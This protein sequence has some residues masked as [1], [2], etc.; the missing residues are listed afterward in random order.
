MLQLTERFQAKPRPQRWMFRPA[1]QHVAFAKQQ[2]LMQPRRR[3]L[4][5]MKEEIYCIAGR[6]LLQPRRL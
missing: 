1:S 3:A 5:G 2:A 4:A 6:L